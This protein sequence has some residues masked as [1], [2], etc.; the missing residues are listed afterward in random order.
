LRQ[1]NAVLNKFI[2][3][4]HP[5][6]AKKYKPEAAVEVETETGMSAINPKIIQI[7]LRDAEKAIV[8]LRETA[9]NGNIK[10]FTTTAH[11]MKSASANVGGLEISEMAAGLED[12]GLNGDADYIAV[13]TEI[14]I[15]ALEAL[16]TKL[17][18]AE[19]AAEDTGDADVI[20]DTEF[21]TEQFEI[22]RNACEN[23]DADTAYAALERLK[24]KQWKTQTSDSIEK[25]RDLLYL[26]SDFDGAVEIIQHF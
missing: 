20:E 14:F 4:R 5:N 6:E 18:P 3:D 10:L 15:E 13:N 8:T 25:I 16:T 12:A 9:A 1:L 19:A 22:I 2:R 17:R 26:S 23:Y 21:L 11:A 7:F 24:E